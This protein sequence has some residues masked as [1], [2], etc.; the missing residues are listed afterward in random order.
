MGNQLPKSKGK[1]ESFSRCTDSGS[2]S[3]GRFQI[4]LARKGEGVVD[5]YVL[6]GTWYGERKAA[7]ARW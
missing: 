4:P 1:E 7:A 3:E 2:R 5:P 6:M